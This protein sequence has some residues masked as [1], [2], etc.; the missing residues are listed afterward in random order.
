MFPLVWSHFGWCLHNNLSLEMKFH[1]CQNDRNE[2]MTVVSL[3]LSCIRSWPV[4]RNWPVTQVKIYDI[5]RNE[6]SY[7]HPLTYNSFP[8]LVVLIKGIW[9][10]HCPKHLQLFLFFEFKCY[11]ILIEKNESYMIRAFEEKGFRI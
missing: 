4:I 11:V 5:F 7:K 6:I 1:F 8:W 9:R 10:P 3:I 2:R